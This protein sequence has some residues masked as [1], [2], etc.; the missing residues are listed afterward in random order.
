MMYSQ[1]DGAVSTVISRFFF[2]VKCHCLTQGIEVHH[3]LQSVH[4]DERVRTAGL[5]FESV[6][7]CY[8][9]GSVTLGCALN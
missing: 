8:G 2:C 6:S 4:R 9:I 3:R 5:F 1:C 7:Y